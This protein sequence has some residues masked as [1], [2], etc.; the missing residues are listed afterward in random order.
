M[1]AFARSSTTL[2]AKANTNK[3]PSPVKALL[4]QSSICFVRFGNSNANVH[5][6]T[7]LLRHKAIRSVRSSETR[8]LK[9]LDSFMPFSLV[10]FLGILDSMNQAITDGINAK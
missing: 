9:H 10:C 8:V 4:G 7:S 1:E 3:P 5:H 6:H 2:F